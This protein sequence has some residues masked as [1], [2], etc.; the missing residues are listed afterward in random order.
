[1]IIVILG[2]QENDEPYIDKLKAAE[3]CYVII[4]ITSAAWADSQYP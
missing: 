3:A 1:M 2:I 4:K